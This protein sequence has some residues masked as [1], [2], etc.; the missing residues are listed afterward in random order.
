[1]AQAADKSI[2]VIFRDVKFN[3]SSIN[4]K[5]NVLEMKNKIKAT[6]SKLIKGFKAEEMENAHLLL[7]VDGYGH[8]REDNELMEPV[9][10][11]KQVSKLLMT[12]EEAI[13]I[14]IAVPNDKLKHGL[15]V[16]PSDPIE[17]IYFEAYKLLKSKY[18]FWF[19]IYKVGAAQ[20]PLEKYSLV[21]K[22]LADGDELVVKEDYPR[23]GGTMQLFIKTLTGMTITIDV[24]PNE[25]MLD[26]KWVI[27]CYEEVPT[28]QQR[29]IFAGRQLEDG[30]SLSDYNIQKE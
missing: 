22:T 19:N 29:L 20:K 21:D 30:R 1:M 10:K 3:I 9:F 12:V 23:N 6:A 15:F 26:V 7:R 2:D 27:R 13:G 18:K 11:M 14:T 8:V 24:S 4:D 16:F 17:D 5:T 25:R 28:Y